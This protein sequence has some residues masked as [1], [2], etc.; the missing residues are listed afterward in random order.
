MF[1][2]SEMCGA[3]RWRLT[4]LSLLIAMA[5]I[6]APGLT[7]LATEPAAATDSPP[8]PQT[9]PP[10]PEHDLVTRVCSACHAPEVVTAKRHTSDEWD[11]II[12]KMVDHGARASDAEQ[13]QILA[14][15]VRFYGKPAGQ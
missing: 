11:D 3:W 7:T 2:C 8:P 14:Y 13:D 5:A 12:A 9:L 10:A 6:T 15:L 4:R 1:L